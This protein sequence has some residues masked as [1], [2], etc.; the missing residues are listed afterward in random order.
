MRFGAGDKISQVTPNGTP[1]DT[2][3]GIEQRGIAENE[4]LGRGSSNVRGN[5]INGISE[6]KQNSVQGRLSRL[7]KNPPIF[8]L[9]HDVRD[10]FELKSVMTSSFKRFAP[11]SRAFYSPEAVCGRFSGELHPRRVHSTP[12]SA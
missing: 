7:V 1:Y 8:P 11:V 5:K 12:V 10:F 4:L 2:V 9:T 6:V 3:R